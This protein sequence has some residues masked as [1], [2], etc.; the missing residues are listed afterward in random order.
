MYCRPGGGDINIERQVV[1]HHDLVALL[2]PADR[3]FGLACR[4]VELDDLLGHFRQG[5]LPVGRDVLDGRIDV[6]E[7]FPQ[8][9]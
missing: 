4:R 3:L 9:L 1:C 8:D 2:H 5:L 7:G 6:L